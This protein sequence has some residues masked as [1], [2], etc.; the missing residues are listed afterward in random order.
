MKSILDILNSDNS[1][2]KEE[3]RKLENNIQKKYVTK[4]QI[5]Q[6]K[7]EIWVCLIIYLTGQVLYFIVPHTAWW[8]YFVTFVMKPNP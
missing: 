2:L 1:V 6:F 5:L 7:G 3:L 8:Q 4:G